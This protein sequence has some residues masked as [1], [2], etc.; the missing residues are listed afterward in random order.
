MTDPEAIRSTV[1]DYGR[2][3]G[4]DREAWV[5][6]FAEDATVEDPVGSEIRRGR[7]A[8]RTF[9]T[10]ATCVRCPDGPEPS[11]QEWMCWAR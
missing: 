8:I 4:A 9:R 1:E 2:T 10:S 3:F 7:D 5:A 6:L 11:A